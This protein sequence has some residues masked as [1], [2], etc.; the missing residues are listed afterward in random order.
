MYDF[1]DLYRRILDIPGRYHGQKKSP[2]D[3][4]KILRRAVHGHE[5]RFRTVRDEAVA[6]DMILVA[7]IYDCWNESVGEPSI[8]IDLCYHPQ[9]EVYFVDIIDWERLAFDVAE[10]VGHEHVHQKQHHKKEKNRPYI[11][12]D[13]DPATKNEQEYLGATEEIEAYG[14]SIAADS[15]VHGIDYHETAMY[16]IYEG[17]FVADP[18]IVRKLEKEIVKYLKRLEPDHV[19]RSGK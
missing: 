7:G 18:N 3:I 19:K 13:T 5:Y 8:D 10:C 11:S 14:F 1:F 4:T 9:Q 15:L 2:S 6:P 17:L 16:K 12:E